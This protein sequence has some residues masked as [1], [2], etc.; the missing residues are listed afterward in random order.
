MDRIVTARTLFIYDPDNPRREGVLALACEFARQAGGK[1]HITISEPVKSREQEEH[2]H[3]L[4]RDIAQ[5]VTVYGKK[6]PAESFKRLLIDA[7]KYD[8]QNDPDLAPLWKSFGSMELVPAL[9]HPGFVV[10]GEQSRR[11]GVKL[12][13]AFIDWLL[14][15]GAENGVRWSVSDRF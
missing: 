5:Q 10:V 13:S 8:T 4:I 11:F 15:Y 9:N 7:F 14:A 3:A 2:Y 12:A 6:L 1:V